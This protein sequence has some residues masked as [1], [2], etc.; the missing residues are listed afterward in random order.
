MPTP[1]DLAT[2]DQLTTALQ[3]TGKALHTLADALEAAADSVRAARRDPPP[4]SN[5][6]PADFGIR[7]V[8][9]LG[10]IS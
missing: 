3:Q 6:R 8:P 2:L 9:V 5:V 7:R 10:R 1:D 4:A